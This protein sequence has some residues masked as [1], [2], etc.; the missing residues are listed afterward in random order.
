M[1]K[2]QERFDTKCVP[3]AKDVPGTFPGFLFGTFL[4]Q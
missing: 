2:M 4:K 3:A 1:K